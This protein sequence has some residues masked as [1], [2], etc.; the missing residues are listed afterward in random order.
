M[1]PVPTNVKESQHVKN[2]CLKSG[3][4]KGVPEEIYVDTNASHAADDERMNDYI[5]ILGIEDEKVAATLSNDKKHSS[6]DDEFLHI[7]SIEDEKLKNEIGDISILI[8]D[9]TRTDAN[10]Q[11]NKDK[12]GVHLKTTHREDKAGDISLSESND[13]DI[14]TKTTI[15]IE[16]HQQIIK[17][18]DNSKEDEGFLIC[19]VEHDDTKNEDGDM[20]I[21]FCWEYKADDEAEDGRNSDNI[22][23]MNKHKTIVQGNKKEAIKGKDKVYE[24]TFSWKIRKSR[25]KIFKTVTKSS[26]NFESFNRF[27]LLSE[28]T[29]DDEIPFFKADEDKIIGM[30]IIGKQ[31]LF[32]TRKTK[33]RKS[34]NLLNSSAAH[35]TNVFRNMKKTGS[36]LEYLET[37][38]KFHLLAEV[39]EE[40][41]LDM[42]Q[43]I[44]LL[45]MRKGDL[46]KCKTCNS[47]KRQCVV[48]P[49]NCKALELYCFFCKKKGHFPK[50]LSCQ[51]RRKFQKRKGFKSSNKHCLK[52]Q[53]KISKKN[54][55]LINQKIQEIE[56][57]IK[58][59]S[60]KDLAEK[61]AEKFKNKSKS[62]NLLSY[63]IKKI[64]NFLKSGPLPSS[65]EK[66]LIKNVL[67]VF[68]ETF[69]NRD[70][71][72]NILFQHGIM[73]SQSETTKIDKPLS[74]GL[75]SEDNVITK[76]HEEDLHTA[77]DENQCV[78][79]LTKHDLSLRHS[80]EGR[81]GYQD[82]KI[83]QLDGLNDDSFSGEEEVNDII[84]QLKSLD[85]PNTNGEEIDDRRGYL[86]FNV[87]DTQ[88]SIIQLDGANDKDTDVKAVYSINCTESE[89]T[90]LINFIRNFDLL[91]EH[92]E[93]HGQ[94]N[95]NHDCFYCHVRSSIFRLN[96]LRKKG[97]K[98]LK[99]NE[100][101][102][103][104]KQ[105]EEKYETNWRDLLPD[106]QSFCHSTLNLME[107]N[108]IKIS[109]IFGLP[110]I[111]CHLCKTA[112]NKKNEL[113]FDIEANE[114]MK[115]KSVSIKH[116]FNLLIKK[117]SK[118]DCCSTS[119]QRQKGNDM[120]LIVRLS[121]PVNLHISNS[122]SFG[123]GEILYQSHLEELGDNQYCSYFKI[124]DKL[125]YQ[126]SMG[127][128]L[129]RTF[130]LQKNVV[131]F[132]V[133]FSLK[134]NQ[135]EFVR[136]D[137]F[138]YDQKVQNILHRK[139][140]SVLN[141]EEHQK[142]MSEKREYEKN[143]N[144]TA[145]RKK[146][147]AEAD[148][149]RNQTAQRKKKFAE[150]DKKR[151]QTPKRQKMHADLDK[152]R[153]QTPQR[154]KMFAESDKKRN[155]TEKRKLM[156]SSYEQTESRK[157]YTYNRDRTKHQRT[158]MSTLKT[159][160]GFDVICSSCLQYK[161]R[162]YCKFV[163]TLT[164]DKI[165]KF[166]IKKCSLLKNKYD[167]QFVCN[168]CIKDIKKDK[169]P[170]RSHKNRFKFANFPDHLIKSLRRIC[171]FREQKSKSNLIMDDQN[172]E[173]LQL[174]LNKLESHLL[175]LCI[176]FIRIAHCPRG[177]YFKVKGDLILISSDIKHSLSR[178]L[179]LQQSL[180]PVSFKRRLSY[181]GAYMEEFIEREKIKM[182]FTWLKRHNHL[183]K[184]IE[185][186]PSLID[187][188]ESEALSNANDFEDD[189]SENSPSV[190]SS[191]QNVF[192]AE[193]ISDSFDQVPFIPITSDKNQITTEKT[194]LF[195]N[196]YCEDT[197]VPSVANRLADAIVDY[198]I[199][200]QIPIENEGDFEVDDENLTEEQYLNQNDEAEMI[201][202]ESIE[203]PLDEITLSHSHVKDE[204]SDHLDAFVNP[205]EGETTILSKIA[206]NRADQIHKKMETIC[207]APGES[208]SFQNWGKRFFWKKSAS[209][210]N[211]H[212]EQVGISALVLITQRMR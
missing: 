77:D 100:Y 11:E 44:E 200:R 65:E 143:R 206:K 56:Y 209:Q 84:S 202:N 74:N 132:S 28:K 87:I 41:V 70:S 146:M 144:Q 105:Y 111:Q 133:R 123:E 23:D 25:F 118:Y 190:E 129:L 101:I 72:S 211:F 82:L 180:I 142:K 37:Y 76:L 36:S 130:G 13:L 124:N 35:A 1:E 4:I 22:L 212:L 149:N 174:Q 31:N 2:D 173:R 204:L 122:E 104:L 66:N 184:D 24:K 115:I 26:S 69:Y 16:V 170:K 51:K 176:P 179:P 113:I 83:S 187:N 68:D 45:K 47:K 19:P 108:D 147:F 14:E 10:H 117:V 194:T 29:H 126:T 39:S 205:T 166:I 167:N 97:P 201:I 90:N 81:N 85:A 178:I 50:S 208:G 121:F 94:C 3:I 207:V 73:K 183:F 197:D 150:A 107:N 60:I 33:K 63:C 191:D 172:Y 53:M 91:W 112:L 156:F 5:N 151:D 195:L 131:M 158:L 139:Y 171:Q 110:N 152:K 89:I 164:E 169:L 21:N 103:Q 96:G 163:N 137:N 67:Q 9:N 59:K 159:D 99:L 71:S 106:F 102:S 58:R 57:E 78:I 145:Q 52:D 128:V 30:F 98:G 42:I 136:Q 181:T 8:D 6:S 62:K 160:T 185:L 138:V 120:I 20:N 203:E 119:L 210:R 148:K 86:N 153:N 175:K 157:Y 15:P 48:N 198:E 193:F 162:H 49:Q 199:N 168:L 46:K 109:S 135:N 186:D 154:Q 12:F 192:D 54:L 125:G 64:H 75:M 32:K 7:S 18:D 155:Q 140:L 40:N 114:V 34:C 177:R 88:S 134:K 127:N 165:N 43:K 182:Y 55:K 61:C 196:K 38:N 27:T 189:S 79:S 116:I 17:D 80:F 93:N 161:S 92:G 188:I 95:F 141:L